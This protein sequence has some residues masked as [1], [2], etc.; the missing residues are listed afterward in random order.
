[1]KD[2]TPRAREWLQRRSTPLALAAAAAL[3]ASPALGIG[4]Q[5]DDHIL[6]IAMSDEGG[7][8]TGPAGLFAF[9]HR[10]PGY[11]RLLREAGAVPWWTADGLRLDFLRPLS[12]LTHWIDFSLW[13]GSP[14]LMHLHSLAWLSLMVLLAGAI[15]R[16]VMAP[17]WTAGLA[18]LVFALDDAHGQAAGWIASRNTIVAAAFGFLA[19]GLHLR[20]RRGWRPGVVLAPGAYLLALLAG[21]GGVATLAY[22]SAHAVTLEPG[23]GARRLGVL[24]PYAAVTVA[25]RVAY[26]HLG[27]GA[28]HSGFYLDPLR[29]PAAYASALV[30]RVPI[31][32]LGQWGLPP[33]EWSGVFP[34]AAAL[35]WCAGLAV[36]AALAVILT[37]LLRREATARFWLI[38]MLLSLPPIAATLPADRLLVFAG[39]GGAGLVGAFLGDVLDRD[40]WAAEAQARGRTEHA[41]AACLAAMH[42]ALAPLLLPLMA[43]S[44]AVPGEAGR[45][46]AESLPDAGLEGT[47][48]VIVNAPDFLLFPGSVMPLRLLEG[49]ALPGRLRALA[50]GPVALEVSRLDERTLRLRSDAG[51]PAG[52]TDSVYRGDPFRPGET[53]ALPGLTVVVE[54]VDAGGLARGARFTFDVPL[55]D[56][57]LA[58][59]AWSNG[60][61]VAFAPPAVGRA[62]ELP[63]AALPF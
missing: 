10:D 25:W 30:W 58:W 62:L 8:S 24:L 36:A 4:W 34:R 22:V 28:A 54:D 49:R 53:V 42:L 7:A 17:L 39:L 32:L 59:Y 21:E 41:A 35:L 37:P 52:L 43:W 48:L 9:F 13:P 16:Q 45:R 31:L 23:R 15:Y 19:L 2:L 60:R 61:Y 5:L 50:T 20:W 11:L 12:S 1:M 3:L 26:D 38:G 18:C 44:V 47:D 56:R 6:R 51:F 57:R 29:E 46:A 27:F 55:E 40:G 14:A 63:V 33:A